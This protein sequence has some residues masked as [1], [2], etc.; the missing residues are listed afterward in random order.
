MSDPADEE[1]L[2]AYQNGETQAFEMLLVRYRR[3]LFNFLLRSTR[4][5]GRAEELYQDVWMRVI[6]RCE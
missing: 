5:R 3:P 4:D 1:L 6:E 2:C